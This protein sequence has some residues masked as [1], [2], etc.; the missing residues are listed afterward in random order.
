MNM[1]AFPGRLS[2]ALIACFAIGLFVM[3]VRSVPAFCGPIHDAVKAGDLA[4]VQALLKENPKLVLIGIDNGEKPLHLAA[5]NGHKDVAE[6]LLA[7]KAEVN[8]KTDSGYTPLHMAAVKGYKDMV[9]L[10]LANKAE[11]NARDSVGYT[12]LHLAARKGHKDVAELLLA[13]KAE[14]NAKTIM[15]I[16][17]SDTAAW[18]DFKD[19]VELLRQH[20]G[21]NGLTG[22]YA[23]GDGVKSPVQVSWPTPPYTEEALR[24]R[25][26]GRVVL[27][28][29][30]RKDGTVTDAKV[31]KKLGY[32]L[33]ESAVNTLLTKWRFKPG[34]RNGEPIDVIST[35]EIRFR[36]N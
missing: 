14:V 10:L 29:I 11:V 17:P 22:V 27:Q 21:S 24:A 9:E 2:P 25:I 31:I 33:D 15:G 1:T 30:I 18:D 5:M 4:K 16:T 35:I 36:M 32:G 19:V 3:L 34:T 13:N 12:P 28:A 20:G 23:P 8:A 7:N 6:L 26:E